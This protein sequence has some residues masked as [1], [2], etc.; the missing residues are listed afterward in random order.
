[1]K[2]T[3][4]FIL[5]FAIVFASCSNIS[6]SAIDFA[7]GS[8][9][10][11]L[12][13]LNKDSVKGTLVQPEKNPYLYY[14]FSESQLADVENF[15][16]DNSGLGLRVILRF[17]NALGNGEYAFGVLYPEDINEKNNVSSM[18]LTN[19]IVFGNC[20]E[21][22]KSEFSLVYSVAPTGKIPCGFFI[23]S[24]S[25]VELKSVSLVE[26]MYGFVNSD[27]ETM[28]AFSSS[29]GNVSWDFSHL[30]MTG[31]VGVFGNE[32]F[33]PCV[34]I[35]SEKTG[36][37]ESLRY[38]NKEIQCYL[39]SGVQTNILL[40]L[41]AFDTPFSDL[42]FEPNTKINSAV[43]C[44][45]SP[46]KIKRMK[47][48]ELP[49]IKTDLGLVL[50]W[51][52]DKWRVKEFEFYNWTLDENVFFFD[53]ADYKIQNE[54]FTR[55]AFFVEKAGYKGTLVSDYFVENKHGYNAHDYK[56]DDLAR[57]FN[58]VKKQNF[59]LN[60][61]ELL[62]K[63][64]LLQNK[65]IFVLDDGTYGCDKNNMKCVISISRESY[66]ATRLSLMAHE[67]WHG[68]YFSQE[69]FRNF[70]ESRFN[71]FDP[72]TLE[73]L[74]GYW[75]SQP[76]LSYDKTDDY[77]MKNEFMAYILQH[78]SD[79]IRGYYLQRAS[80]NSVVNYQKDLCDYIIH[81]NAQHFVDE[82]GIFEKY[83]KENWG[84]APGRVSLILRQ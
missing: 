33:L 62:L 34:K 40:P 13:A 28:F 41:R 65:I 27:D 47:S 78:R 16:R 51:P 55:L 67:A 82:S 36:G 38:G 3:S 42:K 64:L 19:N 2:K 15:F 17:A 49:P 46:E 4:F 26:P 63:S 72:K 25:A 14:K 74:I 6:E 30:D 70:V 60:K 73:F 5:V 23:Y 44:F 59:K 21:S 61:R 45:E 18:A 56:A 43:L 24:T 71:C 77:L 68:L 81:T 7:A 69:N 84:L 32:L 12:L 75:Q 80:W 39:Q 35:H 53:F 9:S 50:D 11:K 8:T 29:G 48:G 66:P 31:A 10:E 76:S 57:F 54:F 22:Q 37:F 52:Q 79:Y 58:E 20:S 1:M 83:V